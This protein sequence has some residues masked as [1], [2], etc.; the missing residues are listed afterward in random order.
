MWLYV[1]RNFLLL[2]V[3]LNFKFGKKPRINGQKI[4]NFKSEL[5]NDI[6][7]KNA[8]NFKNLHKSNDL[9]PNL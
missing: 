2:T 7:L 3:N 5:V 9:G 1:Q 4:E 6:S 8:K